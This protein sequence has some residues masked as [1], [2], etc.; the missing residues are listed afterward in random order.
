MVTQ[1]QS[2][3]ARIHDLAG[4]TNKVEEGT[5]E[6]E[7]LRTQRQ[8]DNSDRPKLGKQSTVLLYSLQVHDYRFTKFW[9]DKNAFFRILTCKIFLEN[10]LVL[11]STRLRSQGVE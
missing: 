11:V 1:Q 8:T 10:S 3:K 5:D 7:E 9:T 4:K 2:S 6:Q